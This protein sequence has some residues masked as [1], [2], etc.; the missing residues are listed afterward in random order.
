M[1]D[2]FY[3]E[4]LRI[5]GPFSTQRNIHLVNDCLSFILHF[6]RNINNNNI[7]F[8]FSILKGHL[9]GHEETKCI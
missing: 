1:D 6:D 5:V 3:H 4:I 7:T 8:T 9:K 2:E